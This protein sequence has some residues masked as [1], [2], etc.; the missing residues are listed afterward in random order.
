MPPSSAISSRERLRR[1]QHR[2]PDNQ[3]GRV[4]AIPLDRSAAPL[5][6][7]ARRGH[8]KWEPTAANWPIGL[9]LTRLRTDSKVSELLGMR[10]VSPAVTASKS[11]RSDFSSEGRL[12]LQRMSERDLNPHDRDLQFCQPVISREE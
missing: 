8:Q 4:R 5:L 6:T 11:L 2:G 10:W 12:W 3:P 1:K 7:G 9:R